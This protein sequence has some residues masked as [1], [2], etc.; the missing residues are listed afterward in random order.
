MVVWPAL[1][2]AACLVVLALM[3]SSAAAAGK[4]YFASPTGAGGICSQ[5]VP[6]EIDEAVAKAGDGDSV[7]LA[8]G[9]YGLPFAGLTIEKAIDFGAAVGAPAI[10]ETTEAADLHVTDKADATLHDLTIQGK[11]GLRLWSGRAD[12]IFVA[13]EGVMADAC[14]LEKGTTLRNSVC[15]TLETSN[16]EEGPSNA[17]D[18]SAS[19]ENQ[20]KPVVLRNVTAIADN[21]NGNAIHLLGAGGAKLVVDAANVIA[22]SAGGPDV[23]AETFG[24]CCPEAHMNIVNSNF[25]EVEDSPSVST[26]T[27]LVTNGNISAPPTFVDA[28]NGDFHVL[29]DSPTLDGGISDSSVGA[30]DLD[31]HDRSQSKCFGTSPVP[32]MGAY[33]RTPTD[34]CPPP[35]PL[36]PP[37]YEPR[38]PV[39]RIVNLFLNKKTGGG[40]LLVEAPGAGTLS[41]T[42]SGVKLVRRTVPSGGGVVS[43]PIQTWAI[44]KVRLAK[45]GKTR[46]RLKVSFEGKGGGFQ[47]WAKGVVLRKTRG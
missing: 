13:Y 15:W 23:A 39:F 12:R 7:S 34:S 5:A 46:V 37:P 1:V 4:S 44:T 40:R 36:P 45:L 19:G 29:G 31:G 42:G 18:I 21:E 33:E 6:C 11:G 14:D 16:E 22:R 38:K 43:L 30:V 8:A 28:A 26:V 35:P 10:L 3:P 9:G 25:G 24:G 17:I 32:D 47:E 2:T 20:D 41:L 27:P